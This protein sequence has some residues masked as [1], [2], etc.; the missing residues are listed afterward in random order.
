MPTCGTLVQFWESVAACEAAGRDAK[1]VL[2][3][4]SGIG[5]YRYGFSYA[6]IRAHH[7]AVEINPVANAV[8][9]HNAD[10]SPLF[11]C[12]LA[13]DITSMPKSWFEANACDIWCMSPPCQPYSRQ[14]NQRD[15][16]DARTQPLK[17]LMQVLEALTNKPKTIVI[18][19]VP[20][21]L[22]SQ[23]WN[24]LCL[25]ALRR[26]GYQ[27]QTLVVST[28]D[29]GVPNNRKRFYAV[30]RL[31]A[32]PLNLDWP[33]IRAKFLTPVEAL[34]DPP[35]QYL[36]NPLEGAISSS[37]N[38][39]TIP[40]ALLNGLEAADIYINKHPNE[41]QELPNDMKCLVRPA[42]VVL[43][44]DHPATLPGS[45]KQPAQT[46]IVPVP[47]HYTVCFTKAYGRYVRGTGSI[48]WDNGRL[49]FFSPNEVARLM[50]YHT[51]SVKSGCCRGGATGGREVA[52]GREV[53]GGRE[54][55]WPEGTEPL[56][57]P[58]GLRT[59]KKYQLLGNSLNP[60]IIALLLSA[61]S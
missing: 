4:F 9:R 8:Y 52:G 54:P 23:T 27:T 30:A 55:S 19:N 13:K 51:A 39:T 5:G 59:V 43:P 48:L 20:P 31:D 32:R 21:F 28:L 46:V 35:N 53:T 33:S 11:S 6:G 42:P 15:L 17:H 37:E 18:E 26:A 41:L 16:E 38:T 47:R 49:R 10:R 2:E 3:L 50:G 57:W 22:G 56:V 58:E 29:S 44:L 34:L 12:V 14:G 61:I 24:D 7:L 1:T 60:K 36:C 45:P 25:P 40:V